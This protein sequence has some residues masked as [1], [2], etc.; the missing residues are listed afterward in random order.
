VA[1]QPPERCGGYVALTY[2]D[3]PSDYSVELADTMK[4]FG[5][6]GTFFLLGS[7]VQKDPATVMHLVATGHRLGARDGPTPVW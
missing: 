7:N 6:R 5:L 4:A 2:D 1:N 3:G